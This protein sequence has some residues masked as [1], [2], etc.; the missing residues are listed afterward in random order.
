MQGAEQAG[1]RA[2]LETSAERNLRF[3]RRLGFEVTDE[4]AIPDSGPTT[5]CMLRYTGT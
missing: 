1:V 4:V 3:Y 2:F 5:W